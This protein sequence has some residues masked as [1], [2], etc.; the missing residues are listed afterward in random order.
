VQ[1]SC[2]A[3]NKKKLLPD[4]NVLHRQTAGSSALAEQITTLAQ[5]CKYDKKSRNMHLSKKDFS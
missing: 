2:N 3:Q 4:W 1:E 5:L